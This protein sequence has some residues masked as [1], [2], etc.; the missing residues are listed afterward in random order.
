VGAANIG[1]PSGRLRL[2]VMVIVPKAVDVG[3]GEDGE[4]AGRA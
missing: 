3:A 1:E 4:D 2:S